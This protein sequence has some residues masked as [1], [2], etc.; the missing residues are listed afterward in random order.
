MV[1]KDFLK[2]VL[3]EHKKLLRKSEVNYIA[4]PHYDELS[5]KALWPDVKKDGN[6]LAFF[7]SKYPKG[8]APPR[9]Y[10]FNVLNTLHPEYLAKIIAH[11]N[12]VRMAPGG[13]KQQR[14]SIEISPF[15]EE[16]LK[17]M[18]YLS[19]KYRFSFLL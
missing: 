1:N 19:S 18:P 17:A 3:A 7:P 15:W 11:A 14:E 5:V 13:E 4:V 16:Q 10:F 2:E 8:K 6:F 12:E 9:E